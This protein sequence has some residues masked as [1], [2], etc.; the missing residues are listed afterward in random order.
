MITTQRLS[1]IPFLMAALA[2]MSLF[3]IGCA[4]EQPPAGESAE[5]AAVSPAGRT[6]QGAAAE[7]VGEKDLMNPSS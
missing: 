5:E 4:G 6:A 3:Y 2:V 1:M 7:S